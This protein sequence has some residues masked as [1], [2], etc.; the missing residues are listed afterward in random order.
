M[1]LIDEAAGT[2]T[3]CHRTRQVL[4]LSMWTYQRWTWGETVRTRWW[5]ARGASPRVRQHAKRGRVGREPGGGEQPGVS[6]RTAGRTVPALADEGCYIAKA[7]NRFMMIEL[8]DRI[9]ANP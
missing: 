2:D 6:Q 4:G 8:P 5:A 3:C 1:A 9:P 7:L